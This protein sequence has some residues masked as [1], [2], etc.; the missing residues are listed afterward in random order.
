MQYG[1][2]F[3]WSMVL[4]VN[5]MIVINMNKFSVFFG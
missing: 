2:N 4:S 3:Y 1:N 5:K